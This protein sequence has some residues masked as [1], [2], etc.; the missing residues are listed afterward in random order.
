[1]EEVALKQQNMGGDY[2]L[3]VMVVVVCYHLARRVTFSK[4]ATNAYPKSNSPTGT[5]CFCE[6]PNALRGANTLL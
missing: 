5:L 3:V 6:A 2:N 4:R 1:M